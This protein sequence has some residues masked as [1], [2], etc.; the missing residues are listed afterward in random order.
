[1]PGAGGVAVA[2]GQGE[3]VKVYMVTGERSC[4]AWR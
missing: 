1:M 2:G 4:V 3:V